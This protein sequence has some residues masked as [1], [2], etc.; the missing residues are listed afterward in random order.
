MHFG[1]AQSVRLSYSSTLITWLNALC[2]INCVHLYVA[3]TWKN[4]KKYSELWVTYV[5][6]L[7]GRILIQTC[8]KNDHRSGY[9]INLM[10]VWQDIYICSYDNIQKYTK[11][12]LKFLCLIFSSLSNDWLASVICPLPF[13]IRFSSYASIP[14][15]KLK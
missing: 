1:M 4:I 13:Y 11:I 3:L 9:L 10:F 8:F 14:I 7:P 5:K 6:S 2:H 15:L 12:K